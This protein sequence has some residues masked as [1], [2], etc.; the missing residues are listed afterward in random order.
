MQNWLTEAESLLAVDAATA[1]KKKQRPTKW[2]LLDATLLLWLKTVRRL[3]VRA[4]AW[5]RS[6]EHT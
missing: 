3:A 6:R 2:P 1:N 4:F 5:H